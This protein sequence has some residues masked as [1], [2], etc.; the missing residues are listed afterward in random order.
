MIL[1]PPHFSECA[2]SHFITS[3]PC[4]KVLSTR[5]LLSHFW[6]PLD[7]LP[8][9]SSQLWS[10]AVEQIYIPETWQGLFTKWRNPVTIMQIPPP[11]ISKRCRQN[12][13]THTREKVAHIYV[14]RYIYITLQMGKVFSIFLQF[15]GHFIIFRKQK[16]FLKILFLAGRGCNPIHAF[17]EAE[18]NGMY[19][20]VDPTRRVM[21]QI[22]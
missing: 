9:S 18:N 4:L 20:W 11:S 15:Q 3:S 1:P 2:L 13:V 21:L 22:W 17:L 16:G 10:C 19:I 5:V 6:Y 14:E 8:L 7:I 12:K